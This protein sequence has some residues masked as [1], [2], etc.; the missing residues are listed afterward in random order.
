MNKYVEVN[1]VKGSREKKIKPK[2]TRDVLLKRK[3]EELGI[4][5]SPWP[6]KPK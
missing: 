2:I 5:I 1:S 3:I 6:S 4:K